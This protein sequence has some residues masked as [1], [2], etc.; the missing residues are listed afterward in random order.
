MAAFF[1]WLHGDWFSLI[2]TVGIIA[3]L[4]FTGAS[5][6]EEAKNSEV[7]N[8]LEMERQHRE[9]WKDAHEREDLKR[10][11]DEKADLGVPLSTA[12]KVFLN[13]VIVHF[14]TGWQMA[15]AGTVLSR[16]TL[17]IDIKGFFS[18]PLPRSVWEETK[19]TRNPR[20]VRFVERALERRGR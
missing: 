13:V 16:E 2:Q 19:G 4:L 12:E 5:F 9:L 10:I 18:L 6:R 17:A 8:I 20:F 14:Q 7:K 1:S 15:M 11:F 3:G